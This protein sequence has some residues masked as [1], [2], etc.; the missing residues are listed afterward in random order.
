MDA[1]AVQER[2]YSNCNKYGSA[3]SANNC[4]TGTIAIATKSETGKYNLRVQIVSNSKNQRYLLIAQPT[5]PDPA[6]NVLT[7]S[8]AGNRGIANGDGSISSADC[9]GR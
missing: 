8:T 1:A 4:K 9:W 5:F 2:Y 6:C 3:G 7:L